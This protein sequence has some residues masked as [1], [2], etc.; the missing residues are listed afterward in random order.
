MSKS[1]RRTRAT[2]SGHLRYAR[3]KSSK[4]RKAKSGGGKPGLIRDLGRVSLKYIGRAL[5][6]MMIS[7]ITIASL[8][9]ISG[10]LVAGYLY[11]SN[12]DYFVVKRV[13]I[14]GINQTSRDEI[15]TAAGLDRPANILTFDLD[16]ARNEISILPWLAEVKVSR[17]MPDTVAIEVREHNPKLLVNL[18]R[19]YYLNDFGEPF[20]ELSPGETPRL[21]IVTGF[22]TD[23]LLNPSPIVKKAFNEIF[24]LV[25]TLSSR[26]DEFKLD[27]I[28]EVNYDMVRGLTLFT[29]NNRLEVKIGFG[30]YEEKFRRLGRVMAHLKQRGKFDG[31]TYLNLEAGPRV[32]V[33]Y[34][35]QDISF[36][37]SVGS[38]RSL[39]VLAAGLMGLFNR[40]GPV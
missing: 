35:G 5:R 23:D 3:G 9:V 15:L 29:K 22:N 17:Q 28:S 14:A 27:N 19:L 26:N 39:P 4:P 11:V 8:A 16:Q 37:G 2:K 6:L 20:K 36:L 38:R 34:E 12:S 25:A 32:T 21:P 7:L 40:W 1:D 30:A 31:V 33:R 24:W 18:G 13:T 10:L